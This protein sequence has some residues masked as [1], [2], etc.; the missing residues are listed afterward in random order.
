MSDFECDA[1]TMQ[2]II[3]IIM[4]NFYQFIFTHSPYRIIQRFNTL[5]NIL[6]IRPIRK[7]IWF[8]TN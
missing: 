4:N 1:V 7:N 6:E 5:F 8:Q 2:D 3:N